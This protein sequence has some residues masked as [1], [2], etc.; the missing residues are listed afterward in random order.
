MKKKKFKLLE[1]S[2]LNIYNAKVLF[3]NKFFSSFNVSHRKEII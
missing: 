1:I 3:S 2:K